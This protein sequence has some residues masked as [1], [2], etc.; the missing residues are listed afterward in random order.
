MKADELLK[1]TK[2]FVEK[3]NEVAGEEK[4]FGLVL[5]FR[6][7]TEKHVDNVINVRGTGGDVQFALH[8]LNK[9]T[10]VINDYAKLRA[11][12]TLDKLHEV[13]NRE[14]A[15]N[16]TRLLRTITLTNTTINNPSHVRR[17]YDGSTPPVG[18]TNIILT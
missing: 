7:E 12:I 5:A 10:N 15:K 17:L 6:N 8:I 18:T 1:L 2:E 9:K 4:G 13:L 16:K 14:T 11:M 3:F